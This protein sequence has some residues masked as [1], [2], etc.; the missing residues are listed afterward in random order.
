MDSFRLWTDRVKSHVGKLP[1]NIMLHTVDRSLNISFMHPKFQ[2]TPPIHVSHGSK[3]A[4]QAWPLAS[5]ALPKPIPQTVDDQQEEAPK[6]AQIARRQMPKPA[7]QIS[8]QGR[9]C[10]SKGTS[11]GKIGMTGWW[12][13]SGSRSGNSEGLDGGI[14]SAWF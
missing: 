12:E 6:R 1:S 4:K 3:S 11:S 9:S 2:M 14:W 5:I 8:Q 13:V 10:Q 7:A